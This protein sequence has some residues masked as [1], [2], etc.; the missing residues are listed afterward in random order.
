MKKLTLTILHKLPNRI[1]FQVSD[2]I[3][4][5]KSFSRSLRKE[6]AIRSLRVNFRI[7]TVLVE[8]NP[9]EIYLQ[10][11]IYRVVTALSIENGMLPVRLVEEYEAKSLNSLSVYSG[12]AILL[13]FL[14]SLGKKAAA[15]LQ[16]TL[17][18]FALG[19]TATAILEHAYGETKRKGFFDIEILPAIY[20]LKSYFNTP[21]ISSIALMWITTF[22]RHLVINHSS[23][24]EIKV[25]R[26]KDKKGQYHYIAD[27]R[28]DNSIENLSDLV[29]C[30]FFNRKKASKGNEKYITITAN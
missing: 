3:Q 29:H 2:R 19:L 13:S 15:N 10:E 4:D 30:V 14:H 8:F 27:V 7:N 26:L 22:G 5:M 18:N 23:S 9:E 20:I 28:D 16:M 17:N 25:F 1:R 11:V 21:S 12:G 6:K 24:K